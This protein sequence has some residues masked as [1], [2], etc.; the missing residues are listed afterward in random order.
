MELKQ[1]ETLLESYELGQTTLSEE[2]Q[3]KAYFNNHKVPTHLEHYGMM[4]Q[5]FSNADQQTFN[6]ELPSKRHSLNFKVMSIAASVALLFG[7]F[8]NGGNLFNSNAKPFSQE[9]LQTYNQ[10]KAALEFLSLNLK[11]GTASQMN[12]L[13][14]VSN[15][16]QKGQENLVLLQNFNTTTNKIFKLNP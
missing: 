6:A 5:Y 15:A 16:I 3:L 14:T 8:L 2:A 9:E 10:A 7:V 13:S 1:V 12:A 11:K 4:F